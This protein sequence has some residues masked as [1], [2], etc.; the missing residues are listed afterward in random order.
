MNILIIGNGFDI[1]HN[2]PTKYTDFLEFIQFFS[3]RKYDKLDNIALKN[4]FHTLFSEH[5]KKV[6][7]LDKLIYN[8]IWFQYFPK[9]INYGEND[10]KKKK[11][12]L[13]S[14]QN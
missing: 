12:G 8:N 5:P 1:E 9:Y 14:S 13:I 2:L 10:E 4:Y 7:Y 3:K 6:Q 11:A